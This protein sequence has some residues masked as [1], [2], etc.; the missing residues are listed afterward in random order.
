VAARL[1]AREILSDMARR[2]SASKSLKSKRA[3]GNVVLPDA[4]ELATCCGGG[5]SRCGRSC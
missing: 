2:A 3:G 4:A 1:A 5:Q